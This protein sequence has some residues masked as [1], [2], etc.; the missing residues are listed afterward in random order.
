MR[1]LLQFAATTSSSQFP[2]PPPATS[3]TI[4]T[5]DDTKDSYTADI[6]VVLAALLCAVICMAGLALINRCNNLRR[7]SSIN[8]RASN[9]PQQQQ[10]QQHIEIQLPMPPPKRGLKKSALKAL[11]KIRYEKQ[12]DTE[13]QTECVICLTEFEEGEE[14]RILPECF[15]KFHVGC[16]DKWLRAQSSCPSCRRVLVVIPPPKQRDEKGGTRN[17]AVI[18]DGTS[19]FLP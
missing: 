7:N 18:G 10:Q 19:T 5:T 6:V 12:D 1:A 9:T 2:F 11:S 8:P 15:H 13:K 16:V 4:T 14:I 17:K 3:T